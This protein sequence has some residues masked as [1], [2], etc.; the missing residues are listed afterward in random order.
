[1]SGST[2]GQMSIL[3]ATHLDILPVYILHLACGQVDLMGHRD[4]LS[5]VGHVPAVVFV[6]ILAKRHRQD[7]GQRWSNS[8]SS[9]CD[10]DRVYKLGVGM[11]EVLS[12]ILHAF[13]IRRQHGGRRGGEG[14]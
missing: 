10:R 1:M 8:R 5:V 2:D 6:G 4:V 3:R 7:Q 14:G 11:A 9:S 12:E 13:A